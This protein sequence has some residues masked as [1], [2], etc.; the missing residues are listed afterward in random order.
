[1]L[2]LVPAG[3]TRGLI[4]HGAT[5]SITSPMCVSY[6]AHDP[7]S[8]GLQHMLDGGTETPMASAGSFPKRHEKGPRRIVRSLAN[9]PHPTQ[10]FATIAVARV[11]VRR[12]GLK[13]A[14]AG[15]GSRETVGPVPEAARS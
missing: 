7:S 15:T 4:P 5:A 12:R 2:D 11:G 1:M 10:M 6:M 9:A 3:E 14:S 8:I 13:G